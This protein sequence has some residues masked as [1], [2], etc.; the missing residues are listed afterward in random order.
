MNKRGNILVENV[1]FIILNLIFLS[2]IVLFLMNQGDG[3]IVLEE[4]YAKEIALVIDYSKPIMTIKVDLS[5]AKEIAEENGI[6]FDN[7][8][9]VNNDEKKVTI[10]L[11]K[12]EGYSYY[13]F[14]NK[15]GTDKLL[16]MYWFLILF[17]VAGGI[18]AMVTV[19]YSSPY[20]VREIEAEILADKTLDCISYT[21]KLSSFVLNDS[22][23]FNEDFKKNF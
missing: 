14:M 11:D 13:F 2:I 12:G 3:K 22:G 15:K 16:S 23:E 6:S 5:K 4:M 9:S 1:V 8:V 18:F 21:G 20:D 17:L 7:V 19:F 10:K